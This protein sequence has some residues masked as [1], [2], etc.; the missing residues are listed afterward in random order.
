MSE[1]LYP[2]ARA[3]AGPLSAMFART[4]SA[5]DAAAIE[6]M[7]DAAF[8]ASLQHQE[9]Y[10]ARISLA[11]LPPHRS[12]RPLRL[13]RPL[14]LGP[15][16]LARVAPAVERPG[17]HLGVFPGAS[18]SLVVWGTTTAVPSHCFVLEV[19]SPGVL[20][21]KH[22]V[23][24]ESAKYRNLAVFEGEQAKL[25]RPEGEDVSDFPELFRT[26]V[27]PELSD[28]SQDADDV[29]LR[30]AVSMR[31]HG[32]G[33]TLLV[34]PSGSEAWRASIVRPLPYRVQPAF[35]ELADLVRDAG[36]R[37][38]FRG[39]A[40]LAHAVEAIAGFTAVDGATV[41][42]DRFELLAFGAKITPL[43]GRPRVE[44]IVLTEPVDGA[45]PTD[46][47]PAQLGGTR[48]LSAAQFA[49]DQQDA[50]ALVASQD[51]RFTMFAW[52]PR[53]R[54]VRAHRLETL[55]L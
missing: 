28:S 15:R 25:L 26:L 11:Y 17:I 16:E 2:A 44:R 52:S 32:R 9:G 14:P 12:V 42:T 5:P 40:A 33:G 54:A 23:R 18:G 53:F 34:V 13:K 1:P 10:E 22:R 49:L 43:D 55:L 7:V 19:A 20:V 21:I 51:R 3:L 46:I 41:M 35:T 47:S 27:A 4:T 6:A 29:L 24:D 39:Q 48:H 30:L 36:D 31:A 50:A 38:R 8:W 37:E 45:E